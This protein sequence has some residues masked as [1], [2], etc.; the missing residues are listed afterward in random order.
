MRRYT[1][2]FQSRRRM[3]IMQA[4][5]QLGLALVLTLFFASTPSL[6]QSP[7]KPTG[8]AETDIVVWVP[9]GAVDP[10]VLVTAD[11]IAERHLPEGITYPPGSVGQAFT[12]GLWQGDSE[13]YRK[14]DPNIVIDAKYA[15]DDVFPE[16][17]PDEQN[18]HLH[19]YNPITQ[20]WVKLCSDVD[21]HENVVSAALASAVPLEE[22]GSSLMIIAADSTP[23]LDQ[24]IDAQGE[25]EITTETSNLRF[26]VQPDTVSVGTH[27][28]I[29]VLPGVS[30]TGL[31]RPLSQPVDIKACQV[32]HNDP[33]RKTRELTGFFFKQPEVG[34]RY[35]SD[36]LSRAGSPTNLTVASLFGDNWID[37]EELG[38][39][40]V[41][42]R[43]I[44]AVDTATL[45]TFSLAIR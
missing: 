37:L 36:I 14:F 13:I 34:F 25:T 43:N 28:V 22:K 39:R 35:D 17:K 1:E 3:I 23:D 40:V 4:S 12:F 6:A 19:M 26:Q 24:N 8:T 29:S 45:G 10:S 9:E 18:L 44:V 16:L 2:L 32:D 30:E 7:L 21:V 42:D 15:D 27:F 31:V 20:S 11:Y 38:A 41:R 5:L 33:Q